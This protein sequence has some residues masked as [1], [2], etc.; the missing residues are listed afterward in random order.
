MKKIISNF[1]INS[2][3]LFCL[4][5]TYNALA[6]PNSPGSNDNLLTMNMRDAD[7]RA[8]IEWI[9][10]HTNKNIIIDPRV[11]GRV[12]VIANDGMTP[13]E[14]YE[15]FLSVLQVHG[16]TA[17]ETNDSIKIIPEI[18]A[19]QLNIPLTGSDNDTTYQE[20]LMVVRVVKVK[21]VAA[22]QLVGLIRPLIPQAGHVA[23][24]PETNSLI[25]SD[26][27]SNI[28]RIIK[29]IESIDLAGNIDIEI[30]KLK[31]AS[32]KD[33][34]KV[35]VALLPRQNPG[36]PGMLESQVNFAG[37][38][39]SNSILMS[40]DPSKRKQIRNLIHRLDKPLAGEG[41]TQVIYLHYLKAKDI[42]PI[43]ESVSGSIQK[44]QKGKTQ[45]AADV[46]VSIQAS[47]ETNAVIITAPPSLLETIKRVI[48]QLDIRR[49]Q[50]LVEAVIVE[51]TENTARELGID[52]LTSASAINGDGW[53]G[54]TSVGSGSILGS[55]DQLSI[56]SGIAMGFFR[57]GDIRA[58]ISALETDSKTNILSTPTLVTL[59][60]EE[61]EILVGQNVPFVTG[62]RD[63]EDGGNPF[64]TITRE[65]VGVRLKI[66]P[67]INQGDAVTLDI[68]QEVSSVN[69]SPSVDAEDIITNK[70]SIKTRVLVEDGQVLVLGGL[71][72]DQ[73]LET[74]R[75]VPILGS[76]PLLGRLFSSKKTT[77]VKTNLM[78]F[79][80]PIILKNAEHAVAVTG[81]RY[82]FMRDQQLMHHLKP[83]TV[84]M[85]KDPPVLP[86][87][88]DQGSQPFVSDQ[89]NAP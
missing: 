59:D 6:E 23:A 24:Y 7:I 12:T 75:K 36:Q 31:H 54:G 14:A 72:E 79:L 73:V 30:I 89:Y 16:F 19:K 17:V 61:A 32:A 83:E 11:K 81:S 65:D 88:S 29:I 45:A 28:N 22:N 55:S 69:E 18:T 71:I 43:L 39:R 33:I 5:C 27:A 42:V 80:H 40:G 70:R 34:I 25:I 77:K 37:D 57:N 51:V 84:F 66:K 2:L 82:E 78:V 64:T 1:L 26:R 38:E 50:V 85:R 60:N 10:E 49:A 52:L 9:S 47:E 44:E 56:S 58:L 62:R 41:N 76:I 87:S 21:N 46:E 53:A 68:E 67:Q 13:K 15:V 35:M 4:L 8:L 63:N 86:E 20:D 48:D 74:N 3:Y